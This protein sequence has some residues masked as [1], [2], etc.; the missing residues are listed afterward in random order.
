MDMSQFAYHN[1]LAVYI[2]RYLFV[3]LGRKINQNR[4]TLGNIYNIFLEISRANF[5]GC[6]VNR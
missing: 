3:L 5:I 4:I 2:S 6:K 1:G